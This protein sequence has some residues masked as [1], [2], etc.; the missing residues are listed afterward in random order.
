[1]C[2]GLQSNFNNSIKSITTKIKLAM[3]K[4]ITL[5]VIIK[6]IMTMVMKR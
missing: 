3:V 4:R 5:M 2:G 1:M 6:M